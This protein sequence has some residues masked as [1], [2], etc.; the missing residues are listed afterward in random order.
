[1]AL[2]LGACG[3]SALDN[4]SAPTGGDTGSGT[5]SVTL[6]VAV[7]YPEDDIS[8][9][10]MQFWADRASELSEGALSFNMHWAGSLVPPQ[11]TLDAVRTGSVDIALQ[12]SS[13]ASGTVPDLSI[14]EAPYAYPT[15]PDELPSFH[16][17]VDPLMAEI[18]AE[19]N[20]KVIFTNPA[21]LPTAI[22][23]TEPLSP[24]LDLSGKLLRASGPWQ[25]MTAE[26]WGASPV[27]FEPGELYTALQQGA[28]DCTM[29]IYN[30]LESNSLAE[31]A[32]YIYRTE[33]SSN[34]QT[35]NINADVWES[36]RP[37]LQDALLKAGQ[38]A[39]DHALELVVS[40]GEAVLQSL[41]DMGGE[42]CTPS[43]DV[44]E[45]LRNATDPVWNA[46]EAE[47]G[48]RGLE[49]MEIVRGHRDASTPRPAFGPTNAC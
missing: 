29:L 38:E 46:I 24:D 12:A 30:L 41:S 14:L 42:F 26:E 27:V 2:V 35:V 25:A 31:V 1:M 33:A 45:G 20:Q 15:A 9:Q 34:Y 17:D 13:F 5:G 28:A 6:D 16:E 10:V 11:E 19:H 22:S 43:E 44:V 8:A 3:G 23:C 36:L 40:E 47:A 4:P 7:L 49:L 21:M 37:E 18:Y 48:E 32:P 39:F